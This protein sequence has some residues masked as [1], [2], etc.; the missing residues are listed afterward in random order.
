MVF[1]RRRHG[2]PPAA[3]GDVVPVAEE[4]DGIVLFFGGVLEPD[5]DGF[6]GAQGV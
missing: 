5:V 2:G 1:V 6:N 4:G 3:T